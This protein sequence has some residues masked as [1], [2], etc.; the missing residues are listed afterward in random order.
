MLLEKDI[1]IPEVKLKR[2]KTIGSLQTAKNSDN[3]GNLFK[4]YRNEDGSKL[5]T[6]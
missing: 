4:I 6:L 3:R 5:R 2:M 1:E